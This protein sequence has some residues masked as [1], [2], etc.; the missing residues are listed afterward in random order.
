[1][2]YWV[3]L[4]LQ[5]KSLASWFPLVKK[6]ESGTTRILIIAV[7]FIHGDYYITGADCNMFCLVDTPIIKTWKWSNQVFSCC[8]AGGSRAEERECWPCDRHQAGVSWRRNIRQTKNKLV[9]WD[10]RSGSE[11]RLRFSLVC[12]SMQTRYSSSSNFLRSKIIKAKSVNSTGENH[13]FTFL[14]DCR[15]VQWKAW[16]KANIWGTSGVQVSLCFQA[17]RQCEHHPR[18]AI[19][20]DS[21]EQGSRN[22]WHTP[23]L[24]CEQQKIAENN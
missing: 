14:Q 5:H 10:C 18:E 11:E 21:W 2:R 22:S 3:H 12:S 20:T 4:H 17:L 8:L 15:K 13:W 9:L 24:I 16:R 23:S 19:Q 6:P 7:F 1:M